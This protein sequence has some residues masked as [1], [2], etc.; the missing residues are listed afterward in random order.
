MARIK[1]TARKSVHNAPTKQEKRLATKLQ[2]KRDKNSRLSAK[3][4]TSPQH[5]K[6]TKRRMRN[7]EGALKEIRR[8]QRNGELLIPKMPFRRLV[9]D[10]ME[11]ANRGPDP[12]RIQS[13]AVDALQEAAETYLTG[14]FED[15]NMCAIH[16][17]RVTVMVK[18]IDLVR[19]IRREFP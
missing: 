12:L 5:I 18:D 13:M 3:G 11:K 14:L 1:Q 6:S 17:R 16:G 4:K 8:Y 7:G 2:T 19:R 9:R 10:I 15:A